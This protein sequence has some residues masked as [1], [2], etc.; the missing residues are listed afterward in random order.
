[1]AVTSRHP[2]AGLLHHSD[3]GSQY[4]SADYQAFLKH[5]GMIVSMS[6]K[7]NCYDNA[8]MESCFWTVKEE[9]TDRHTYQTREDAKQ[10]I[11]LYIETFYNRK[12]RHSSLGY[13][14]PSVY[15]EQKLWVRVEKVFDI[16]SSSLRE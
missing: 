12:R 13:V 7:G 14:S 8:M 3:R 9:R 6:R 15:E 11:F 16:S 1:M 5:S 10:A 4:T 2:E